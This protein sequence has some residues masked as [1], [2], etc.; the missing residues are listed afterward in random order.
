MSFYTWWDKPQNKGKHSMHDAQA[1]WDA[2]FESAKEE[3]LKIIFLN[4]KTNG[5]HTI[6]VDKLIKEIE[7]L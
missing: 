1:G 3:C 7:G 2:G 4:T 5:K 6:D